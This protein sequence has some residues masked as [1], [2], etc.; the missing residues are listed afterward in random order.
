MNI[1][2]FD[3]FWLA[4]LELLVDT[5]ITTVYWGRLYELLYEL[6]HVLLTASI[7]SPVVLTLSTC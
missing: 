1:L 6:L 4:T 3:H 5:V 7:C 2:I